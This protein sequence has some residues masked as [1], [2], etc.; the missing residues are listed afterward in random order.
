M[1][2]NFVLPATNDS[3]IGG[4]KI[5][6][7]YANKL[8]EFGHDVTITFLYRVQPIN[9]KFFWQK[10]KREKRKVFRERMPANKITWFKL[11]ENIKNVFNVISYGEVPEADV[12][13]ATSA[14]SSFFVKNLPKEKGRK[15]YFIQGYED[16][17]Y[18]NEQ[19]LFD[20]YKLGL[21]NIVISHDLYEKVY[22]I[23][24]IRP[25]Y[26]PNFFDHEEFY[27]S[28]PVERR[29]NVVSLLSHKQKTKR[30]EFGLQILAE[31]K[32]Y[33]PNLQ[34]ELFGNYEPSQVLADYV[35]FTY[36][37]TIP[38]L[39]DE[40]YGKS[41]IYLMPSTLEGWG[42]TGM[43]AMAS[44]AVLVASNI[45]GITEY[46][47]TQNSILVEPTNYKEFI[48]NI[49]Y[50]LRNDDDRKKIAEKS[51]NDIKRF[52]LEKATT[53]LERVLNL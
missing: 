40:I 39:R 2:V 49:V 46:A 47:N 41:K 31:V 37:A 17:W 50:L 35:H 27:V 38:D 43:E 26:L 19:S 3:P 28:N 1:K 7:Q 13:I 15:F 30:T 9:Q 10:L 48:K 4:Y 52:S 21:K 29:R 33:V 23:S 8:S 51:L 45:G 6:Y 14:P 24:N 53:N 18:E 42:L 22:S 16:W 36:K 20:T 32:K 12:V 11:N 34:V 25:I 44:G 5:V